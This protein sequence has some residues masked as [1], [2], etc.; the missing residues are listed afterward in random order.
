MRREHG[1][2]RVQT[3]R[4]GKVMLRC[5]A[6]SRVPVRRGAAVQ[7]GAKRRLENF[8]LSPAVFT[9]RSVT[10]IC[11]QTFVS[12]WLVETILEKSRLGLHS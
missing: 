4:A 2:D 3:G 11:A 12:R 8:G 6:N 1:D 10:R 9:A 7:T 5:A